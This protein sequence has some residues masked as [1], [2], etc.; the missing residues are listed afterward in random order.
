[1]PSGMPISRATTVATMTDAMVCI[2]SDHRSIDSIEQQAETETSDSSHAT[3]R[4]DRQDHEDD[5]HR[6]RRQAA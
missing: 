2:V 5:D 1:M 4:Q 3:G 6:D